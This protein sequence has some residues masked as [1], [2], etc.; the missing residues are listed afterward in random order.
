MNMPDQLVVDIKIGLI[1]QISF[2]LFKIV[3]PILK[4]G[5]DFPVALPCFSLDTPNWVFI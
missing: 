1:W 4:I 2:I 3:E 5:Q